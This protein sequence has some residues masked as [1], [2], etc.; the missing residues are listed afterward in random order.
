MSDAPERIW[1]SPEHPDENGYGGFWVKAKV[2]PS[3][4][5]VRADIAADLMAALVDAFHDVMQHMPDHPDTI[6]QNAAEAL[7]AWEARK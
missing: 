5:Y 3:V 6:W 7:A 4:E 2:A 1:A